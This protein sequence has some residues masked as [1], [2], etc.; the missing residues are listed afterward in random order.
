MIIDCHG[1]LHPSQSDLESWDFESTDQALRHQQRILSTYHRPRAVT[2]SGEPAPD[3][4]QLLWDQQQPYSWSGRAEVSLRVEGE[5][6]VW[7]K[8]GVTYSAPVRPATDP[9]HLIALMDAVGV[10]KAVLH[11]SLPYNRH[12]GRVARAYPGRFLPIGYVKFDEDV[13]ATIAALQAAVEDGMVG[14]YQN[15]LP[16]W[17]GFSDFHSAHFDPLW[18]EVD[19]LRLPVCTM[20]WVSAA[21]DYAGIVNGVYTPKS[22]QA[23]F[24]PAGSDYAGMIPKLK[25]WTERFPSIRRI[26][27]HGLPP[28]VLLDGDG[29]QY[30]VSDLLRRLVG[31]YDTYLELLPWAQRNYEHPRTDE[32]IKV[33]YD[34]FGPTKFVWGSEFI[35]AA[36]PHTVE[37]YAELK[38]Y[39]DARCPY[40][41]AKDKALI[42]GGNL[43]RLFG[44]D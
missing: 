28:Q 32:M 20:G 11:A 42:L 34:T 38:G 39:F 5:R 1:H 3:A 31:D 36:F 26:L 44:L 2:A 8:D 15:P 10:D 19:R 7:D 43:Q 30:R 23:G 9:A 21:A 4:W 29:A 41:P 6:F 27:V 35:K 16:G 25:A 12:Y 22:G 14:V 33:L 18:R 37:H 13:T 17:S 24:V 40:M